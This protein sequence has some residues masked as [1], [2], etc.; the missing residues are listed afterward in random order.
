MSEF[1]CRHGLLD[2]LETLDANFMSIIDEITDRIS[3]V[4]KNV[5]NIKNRIANCS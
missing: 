5:N 1:E 2:C 4:N 3:N